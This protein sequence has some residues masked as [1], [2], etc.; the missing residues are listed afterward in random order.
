MSLNNTQN[1]SQEEVN[2]IVDKMKKLIP[3]ELENKILE[4]LDL[5][6]DMYN[7]EYVKIT[8]ETD[9]DDDPDLDI[10]LRNK[11]I[12]FY[13][14]K[15]DYENFLNENNYS[16][17]LYNEF[18]ILEELGVCHKEGRLYDAYFN[19]ALCV[20]KKFKCLYMDNGHVLLTN[21]TLT[22]I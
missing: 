2:E 17:Y 12:K 16:F 11:Y 13:N 1:N 7:F 3:K 21:M 8:I 5:N 4:N 10:N 18:K 22:K 9:E 19:T 6:Y 20:I 15:K 14:T